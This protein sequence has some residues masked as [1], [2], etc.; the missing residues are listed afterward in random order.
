MAARQWMNWCGWSIT[1]V[2]IERK[3]RVKTQ[4]LADRDVVDE[5]VDPLVA[6]LR[7][8]VNIVTR[9]ETS[10]RIAHCAM[11]DGGVVPDRVGAQGGNVGMHGEIIF[12]IETSALPDD[13]RRLSI[14]K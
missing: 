2:E 10:A 14:A 8:A 12:G 13:P 4:S 1:A 9:I 3:P 11:P 6:H 7:I 5:R